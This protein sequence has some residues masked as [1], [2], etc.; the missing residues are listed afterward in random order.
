[1]NV[2]L[3]PSAILPAGPSGQDRTVSAASTH[4]AATGAAAA[5]GLSFSDVLSILNPF[6]HIPIVSSIYRWITGETIHPVA[7][8]IGGALYGGPIGLFT[9][10]LNAAVE[11]VKGAD[12]GEQMV[13]MFGVA[14]EPA[15]NA[16]AL[17]AS[18]D[19]PSD[20]APPAAATTPTTV[21]ETMP[22]RPD[23]TADAMPSHTGTTADGGTIAAPVHH[24]GP[25]PDATPGVRPTHGRSLAFYQAYAGRRLPATSPL[26]AG[27][28][29]IRAD[30]AH[31]PVPASVP[32]ADL[33]D[34]AHRTDAPS[35]WFASAMLSG[36][37]KYRAMQRLGQTATRLDVSH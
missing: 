30:L 9:S 25:G 16:T 36:L 18:A 6:Q 27:T 22:D 29:P 26:P 4:G 5:D 12:L 8:A 23:V 14:E 31:A 33:A 19:T 7:R 21:A 37:D 17:A 34:A 15:G 2:P 32:A 24:T 20:D 35:A 28:Y 10:V 11:Q 13:A 3:L 1:M